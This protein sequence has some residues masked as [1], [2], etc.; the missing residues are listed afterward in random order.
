VSE[1]GRLLK[2]KDKSKLIKLKEEIKG[3]IEDIL[4]E[5]YSDIT[6]MNNFVFAAS[7]IMTQK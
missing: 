7:T 2:L 1:R 5:Y 4:E 6:D 3:I